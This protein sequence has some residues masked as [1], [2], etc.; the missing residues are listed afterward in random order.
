MQ[1]LKINDLVTLKLENNKTYIYIKG[2]QFRQCMYLL[3]NS[4][5]DQL[6][7]LLTIDFIDDMANN[8]DHSL[9]ETH[10]GIPPEVEFWGHCSNIQIWYENNYDTRLIHSNL[11]FPLLRELSDAGDLIVKRVFKEE[12]AKRLECGNFQVITFLIEEGYINYLNREDFLFCML[13]DSDAEIIYE[14]EKELGIV[15]N[16]IFDV[17][18]G[19]GNIIAIIDKDV[20]SIGFEL[21]KISLKVEKLFEYLAKLNSIKNSYNLS[22]KKK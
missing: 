11:A 22:T 9:E 1:E 16:I 3:I 20:L 8:L 19:S 7:D 10:Y 6:E 17:D 21:D 14:I 13:N 12:I 2:K 5:I 15:F 18:I 4:K